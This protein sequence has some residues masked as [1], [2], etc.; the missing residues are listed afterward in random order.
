[1]TINGIVNDRRRWV[2]LVVVCLGQ[3]MI[4]VDGTIVNVALPSIQRDLHFSPANLTWVVNA[5]LIT[6]GSLVLLA[7]RAGDLVG[8][9]RV[10]LAGVALFT[11][12]SLGCGLAQSPIQL[13]AARLGQGIGAS[14]SAGVVIAIIVSGFVEADERA[15][16]MSVFTFTV[17]GG[18]SIGLL[19][20]GLLVQ[21]INWHWIFFINVPIGV[22]TV[23]LGR[24]LIEENEGLGLGGGVDIWGSLLVT[25][26]LMTGAY[27]IVTAS[28]L[29]W[30]SGHTLGFGAAAAALL[31]AFGVLETRIP[32]PI[33]PLHMLRIRSLSGASA[34][35][36]LLATGMFT[37][38]FLGALYL[39]RVGGFSAF[40][41]GLAFLPT[42]VGMGI[43]SAGVSARLMRRFGPRR[44]LGFGLALVI[45]ALALMAGVDGHTAYFP[46][47]FIAYALIGMGGGSAFMPLTIIAMSEVH[48]SDSGLAAGISNTAMQNA[49]A[50][51]LAA[52]GTIATGHAKVLAAQGHSLTGSL[53]G[54]YQ[55]GFGI[56]AAC[57]VAGL[58]VVLLVLR[59]PRPAAAVEADDV[60]EAEAA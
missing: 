34:A 43:L 5:Y 33:I 42:T 11:I 35:R 6:Y 22:L 41:T 4:M 31:V 51:G 3:L 53:A 46:R 37:T 54:G 52:I 25:A 26:A 17:A 38:F 27:A 56:A 49:A 19:A 20:G 15:R 9:K 16:A 10:F 29:G 59:S 60:L 36:A 55:L 8:R 12:A 2:A 21:S 44:L 50:L 28:D 30:T 7:G 32:N 1:M 24:A 39:Q 57:V 23:L 13:I 48:P 40:G 47:V 18:G 14:L 58:A 45:A